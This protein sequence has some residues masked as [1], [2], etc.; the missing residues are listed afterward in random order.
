MDEEEEGCL[1][2]ALWGEA[3]HWS[4]FALSFIL[5]VGSVYYCIISFEKGAID[6]PTISYVFTLLLVLS[7]NARSLTW[8]MQ[9]FMEYIGS[10]RDGISTIMLPHE[11]IDE[12]DAKDLEVDKG[13]IHYKGISFAYEGIK[14]KI[15]IDDFDLEIKSGEKVGFVGA[16]GAGKSTLVSLLLR[17]Y[18]LDKGSIIIDGQ[19]IKKVTQDSL[20]RNISMIPQ[21]TALFHRSLMDNIRYGD[22]NASDHDVMEAAKKAHAHEFISEM[23]DSYGTLVGER[24][25]KL[26]GGQRQRIAIARAILK[27]SQILV[28]DEATSALDSESEKHIQE[29][30]AKL[31][32][33]K[34][35]LAIAHRL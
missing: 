10:I 26:S 1:K 33:G 17:F 14:E 5:L 2:F 20:R 16:S 30:L 13:N 21:D 27:K 11:I 31:M 32:E 29:S 19:D 35:V 8:S 4:H 22:L 15:V 3:I 25:V 12:V 6:L 23:P 7:T 24:G 18:E 28:L 34:T 9:A